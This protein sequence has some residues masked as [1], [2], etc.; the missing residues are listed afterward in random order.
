MAA[1][2]SR[3]DGVQ[4]LIHKMLDVRMIEG[5][6]ELAFLMDKCKMRDDE[7]ETDEYHMVLEI[8][9]ELAQIAD[10]EE[11]KGIEDGRQ[12]QVSLEQR[13]LSKEDVEE[14]AELLEQALL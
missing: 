14:R 7:I 4:G 2:S 8:E 12:L 11:R 5:D 13:A 6:A 3:N 9:L 1:D 10:R